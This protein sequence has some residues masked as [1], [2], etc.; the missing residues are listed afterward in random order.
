QVKIRGYRIELG[1]LE[2]VLTAHPAVEKAAVVDWQVGSD[3]RLAAYLVRSSAAVAADDKDRNALLAEIKEH[4]TRQVPHY[5]IPAA[6]VWLDSLP[7]TSNGKI[8]RRA[9]PQPDLS[10]GDA[11]VEHVA[12]RTPLEERLAAIW[13]EV[14]ELERIGV[15]DNFFSLGGHSLL[16]VRVT[17]R[18]R[19]AFKLAL[20]M[21]TLFAA[22]TLSELAE[23]IEQLQASGQLLE[24]PL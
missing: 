15:H 8:N 20:P 17:A 18:L 5:M 12:P 3:K 2:A 22:P 19:A 13:R 11:Q 21:T 23:H 16:A 6:F 24:L 14:L 1:E 4:L 7:L 10:R 9:L